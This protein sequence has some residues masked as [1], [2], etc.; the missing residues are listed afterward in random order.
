M[1][2]FRLALALGRTVKELEL[3]LSGHELSEWQAF[4]RLDPFGEDRADLR[5]AMLISSLVNLFK[6]KKSQPVRPEDYMLFL[7]KRR[8]SK[9]T[10]EIA[11]VMDMFK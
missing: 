9:V 8:K 4:F 6:G 10:N 3:T 11:R 2:L 1:F 7:N 5:N